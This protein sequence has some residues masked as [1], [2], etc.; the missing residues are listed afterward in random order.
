MF[1]VSAAM[2]NCEPHGFAFDH[3]GR[4]PTSISRQRRVKS[5]SAVDSRSSVRLSSLRSALFRSGRENGRKYSSD[6]KSQ[7][8][9]VFRSLFGRQVDN[10]KA[11]SGGDLWVDV[12][13]RRPASPP[14]DD[15]S[16]TS[17]DWSV[18]EAAAVSRNPEV[19]RSAATVEESHVAMVRRSN[20]ARPAM[21]RPLPMRIP[22]VPHSGS[23]QALADGPGTTTEQAWYGDADLWTAGRAN[24]HN[25]ARLSGDSGHVSCKLNYALYF[26]CL[27][28]RR[29]RGGGFMFP[30]RLYVRPLSVN[31]Y[32]T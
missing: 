13:Q 31:T 12:D 20:S 29:I 8:S 2:A 14:L 4:R 10:N 22:S 23:A 24:S 25:N 21:R 6:D 1:V 9:G 11:P 27:R 16:V 3:M 7:P 15:L 28:R 32:F 30:G 18:A 26:F 5:S 17:S 19:D